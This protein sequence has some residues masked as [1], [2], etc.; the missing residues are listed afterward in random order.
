VQL[1]GVAQDAINLMNN[2]VYCLQINV[3][4]LYY[5]PHGL[6]NAFSLFLQKITF[7]KIQL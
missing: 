1:V 7:L 5:L 4:Y 6:N 2:T 3:G